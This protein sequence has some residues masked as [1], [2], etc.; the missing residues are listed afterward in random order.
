MIPKINEIKWELNLI[1]VIKNKIIIFDQQNFKI[2][3]SKM[4]TLVNNNLILVLLT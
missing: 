4:I 2:L 1:N 3:K